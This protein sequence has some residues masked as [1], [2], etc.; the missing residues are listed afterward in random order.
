VWD[1]IAVYPRGAIWE[2]SPPEPLY[3]GGPVVRVITKHTL[4][5]HAL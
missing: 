3:N 5:C 4:L 2:G 1:Y